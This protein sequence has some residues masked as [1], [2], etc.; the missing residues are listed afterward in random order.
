MREGSAPIGDR[1]R[2]KRSPFT[3]VSPEVQTSGRPFG[4]SE[5]LIISCGKRNDLFGTH[6]YTEPCFGVSA[7]PNA[8]LTQSP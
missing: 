6:S 7:S 5:A 8:G 3:P 4:R 2:L 1:K